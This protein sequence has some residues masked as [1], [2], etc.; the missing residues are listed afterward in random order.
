V[1]VDSRPDLDAAFV[2]VVIADDVHFLVGELDYAFFL[3]FLDGLN[4]P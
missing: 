3:Q 1:S 4:D 2:R